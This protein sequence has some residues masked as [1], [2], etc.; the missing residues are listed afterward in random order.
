MCALAHGHD[1]PEKHKTGLSRHRRGRYPVLVL[2]EGTQV[3]A[4][5]YKLLSPLKRGGMGKL[6]TA[7]HLT[8]HSKVAIK[9]LDDELL[10]RPD[11]VARFVREARSA[12]QIRSPHIVQILD[13]GVEQGIP[14]IAMELLQGETLAERLE[15]VGALS[16]VDT[17]R[18]LSQVARGVA[19]A[20]AAG[21]VHRDLKPS[22]IFL[23]R[24]EE[25]ENAKV[26]DFGI[27]K[28]LVPGLEAESGA[29]RTGALI[30]S[31]H[32]M[33]PEQAEASDKLDHRTDIWAF[34]V[35][36]FEC[37]AGR[38]PFDQAS[39]GSQLLAI[40]AW[41]L[42]V[43]SHFASV[44]VGF[45]AWFARACARA[46]QARFGSAHEAAQELRAVCEN[47]KRTALPR[48]EITQ[49]VRRPAN[50]SESRPES[51]SESRSESRRTFAFA[52]TTR[53]SWTLAM[54]GRPWLP[55]VALGLLLGGAA[56][57][58][59][60][61]DGP[62]LASPEPPVPT[63]PARAQ[64]E[65][66]VAAKPALNPP[67]SPVTAPAAAAPVAAPAAAT[68]PTAV[69]PPRTLAPK[70]AQPVEARG[71]ARE[72]NNKAAPVARPKPRPTAQPATGPSTGFKA[73][74]YKE[75]P[76]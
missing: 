73:D 37:M 20:H 29:T 27:A 46:P 5:R 69:A 2:P 60:L 6:W 45:D 68:A 11:A 4:G 74:P 3:L 53:T 40:C 7:E 13:V 56:L 26:L 76:Y 61:R 51:R 39:L 43:P 12:A 22:N 63:G 31:P 57:V 64:A 34:G 21:L 19:R 16:A 75:D 25:E 50:G 41:P 47:P 17:A 65:A 44:P 36:A 58:F 54:K 42:P 28:A 8:L 9:L 14:F 10:A 24:N 66:P 48:S 30:G 1:G 71:S 67:R 62:E 33:S 55:W 35:V 70:P 38:R 72:Q 32:Y 49:S 52:Q 59:A 18:I 23:E 15:R